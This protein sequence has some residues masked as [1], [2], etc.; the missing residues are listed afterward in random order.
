MA[1]TLKELR[2]ELGQDLK[3][4]WVGTVDS[5]TAH[6]ITDAEIK[7]PDESATRFERCWCRVHPT[8][9]SAVTRRLKATQG[10]VPS[11][12][13]IAWTEAL[14]VIPTAADQYELH[15]LMRPEELNR[16]INK[17]L[18]R[19]WHVY[20]EKI[21]VVSGQ[22]EY[23][24]SALTWFTDPTQI[25]DVQDIG[26]TGAEQSYY[27]LEWFEVIEEPEA[28]TLTLLVEPRTYDEMLLVCRRPYAELTSDT[29]PTTCPKSWALAAALVEVYRYLIRTGPGED[30]ARHEKKLAAAGRIFSN[31][32]KMRM[33]RQQMRIQRMR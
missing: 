13:V 29:D 12:G 25:L 21:P 15:S 28:A 31:E 4:C 3:E 9:G 11:T 16:L 1:I 2:Q 14:G 19:C 6:S 10:Y 18:E 24:L 22:R 7:D 26:G 17:G 33:P 23:D 8:G 5:A 20:R 30:T 32:S 27:P